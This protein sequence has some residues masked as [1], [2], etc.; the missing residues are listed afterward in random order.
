MLIFGSAGIFKLGNFGK[1]TS[2]KL[3]PPSA[4][5]APLAALAASDPNSKANPPN[6][7]PIPLKFGVGIAGIFIKLGKNEVNEAFSNKVN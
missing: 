3:I 2:G 4:P 5:T 6:I 7:F 1:L